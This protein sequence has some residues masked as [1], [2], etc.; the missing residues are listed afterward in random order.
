MDELPCLVCDRPLPNEPTARCLTDCSHEFCLS[1]L[2]R[3]LA[4]N[5]NRCPGCHA[6]VKRVTQLLPRGEDAPKPAFVRFCNA[7]YTLNVSIWAVDDP[8]KVLASLFNFHEWLQRAKQVVCCPFSILYDF[9]R[10]L[11]GNVEEQQQ[12]GQRGYAP[13]PTIDT[14]TSSS[15]R[16]PG[17]VP[18][19]DHTAVL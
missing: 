12:R 6:Q 8:A 14:S 4:V 5:K 7:V 15:F 1:C 17:R 9:V 16:E 19:P 13:I 10:S 18:S 11:F 3:S 2:C